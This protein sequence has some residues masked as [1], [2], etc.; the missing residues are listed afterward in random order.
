[1]TTK[2]RNFVLASLLVLCAGLGIGFLAYVARATSALAAPGPDEMRFVPGDATMVAFANVQ[3]VMTS[4]LRQKMRN[5]LG[6][7]GSRSFQS[8]TGI[9]PE[10]DVDR[11][12]LGSMPGPSGEPKVQGPSLVIVR[13]RF[14]A[15]KIERAMRDRGARVDDYNGTRIVSRP[16]RTAETAP[17]PQ[18]S[19]RP[20]ARPMAVAFLEPGLIAAGEVEVVRR[21]IDVGR[22]GGSALTNK[23]LIDRVRSLEGNSLWAVGR[24]DALPTPT[25]FAQGI[26]GQ[27]PPISWFAVS[28][29]I[30]AGIKAQFAAETRDEASANGL[31]DVIR[32]AMAIGRMQAGSRPELQPV[33]QS[34][35]VGGAGQ[36]V[37]LSVDLSP[38]MLDMLSSGLQPPAVSPGTRPSR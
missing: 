17:G 4:E 15:V 30:D 3:H 6:T 25:P 12:V 8:E 20:A 33:L 18:A 36:M 16:A 24:F 35:Q 7:D 23:E 2:T 13:G 1:M 26:T 11:V 5:G 22:S 31:R 19:A 32:G 34:V 10:T 9:N 38:Q 28:G 29:Q 27:L 14:D 21:A 37:T